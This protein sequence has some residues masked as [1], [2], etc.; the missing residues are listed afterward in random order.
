MKNLFLAI[1]F[2]GLAFNVHATSI[3]EATEPKE[4]GPNLWLESVYVATGST[5]LDVGD[6]VCSDMD[7]STGDDDNWV[8]QCSAADTY[9]V[10][11]VVWPVGI[12]AGGSGTIVIR[13]PVA[14][15]TVTGHLGVVNGVA[16][17]SATAGSAQSCTTQAA[18]F[19]IVTQVASGGSAIVCV[20]CNK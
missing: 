5:A 20:N 18:N 19:G 16:C 14:T 8:E 2:L 12:G 7:A 3:P 4:G 9:L 10:A 6:V 13:G 17:S 11:G 1:L 15:D